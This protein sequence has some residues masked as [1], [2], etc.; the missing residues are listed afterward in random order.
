MKIAFLGDI[1][2]RAG[3][4]AAASILP[5]LKE[6]HKIDLTIA[7]LENAAGGFGLTEK[8]LDQL[9]KG[10]VDFFTSGNHIWDKKEGI[11][12]LDNRNNVIR[13]ANY[14]G[15]PP[16]KGYRVIQV[17]GVP[18]AIFN[19]QGRVFMPSIDCPFR[20]ID[21]CLQQIG[22][23]CPVKIVDVHAEAT[24]EKVAMGWYLDGRVSLVLGTHTH[25]ATRDVKILPKGTGYVTDIGM[26]GSH[27]SVLGVSKKIIIQRFLEMRPVRFEIASG[28][29]RCDL[30]VAEVDEST[31]RTTGIEHMQV[32]V[33]EKS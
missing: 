6:Q 5:K 21:K 4:R 3:R 29:L 7:N 19:V 15:N 22:E 14:P 25:V 31:G 23:G 16:G 24:S 30:I 9:E 33:D 12:L 32:R 8:A 1:V 2:G 26:T 17:D 20:A 10:G 28:D 18:V 11:T 13:P 27:D